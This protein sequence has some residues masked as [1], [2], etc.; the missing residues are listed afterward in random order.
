MRRV[1]HRCLSH[2]AAGTYHLAHLELPLCPCL[3]I[4]LKEAQL[5]SEPAGEHV[6]ADNED[7]VEDREADGLHG[8][9]LSLDLR[10]GHLI[11]LASTHEHDSSATDAD[12]EE[13]QQ[14][15]W[16]HKLLV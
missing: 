15:V 11:F 6:V 8:G 2:F 3:S 7:D 14:V 16:H 10:S 4:A 1:G 5:A 13:S 9:D 12:K